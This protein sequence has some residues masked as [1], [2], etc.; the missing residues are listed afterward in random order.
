VKRAPPA[1]SR[2]RDEWLRRVE[3]EYRS[4]VI[5]QHLGLWLLQIGAS[6]DEAKKVYTLAWRRFRLPPEKK[7]AGAKKK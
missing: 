6:P 7:K 5:A 3:A 1:S 2:V 4:A